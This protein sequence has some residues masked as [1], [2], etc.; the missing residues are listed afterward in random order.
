MDKRL[1]ALTKWINFQFGAIEPKL[2]PASED[3]S[4]RRYFRVEV[5][6]RS[7]IAMDAPPETEDIQPY[8]RTARQ[9]AQIGLNVPEVIAV[10]QDQGFVLLSDLGRMTYLQCLDEDSV[11]RLYGDALAALIVLQTGTFTAPDYFPPYDQALLWSEMELFPTWYV[12]QHMNSPVD[13]QRQKIID[14]TFDRLCVSALEQPSVW[15]HRDYHSRNLMRTAQKNP[16]VLDFQDAVTGPI[17]YDLVSLLR[18]CY[19]AWPEQRVRD[20]AFGYQSLAIQ[21]GLPLS[22]DK[23]QF[24]AW[25]DLMG[26]Q[27][28]IKVL[29]IF[30]RL[31]HRDGKANYLNDLPLVWRY[32]V[33]VCRKYEDL[34]PFAQLLAELHPASCSQ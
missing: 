27:R 26:V 14:D 32:L 19:I 10:E 12:R 9:F 1:K 34:H 21:S 5:D 3:A 4:F 17:T 33:D 22:D 30:A 6:G 7:F 28:H 24:I 31:F 13:R 15:V 16:G 29:G 11:D 23:E 8:L 2:A 20:W 25:F 18:D